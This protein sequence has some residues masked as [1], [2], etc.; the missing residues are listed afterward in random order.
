MDSAPPYT[1]I[2]CFISVSPSRLG[3]QGESAFQ[4]PERHFMVI[5]PQMLVE[6][7]YDQKLKQEK[8]KKW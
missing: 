2:I 7:R 8:H 6:L 1:V 3:A 4:T 5:T